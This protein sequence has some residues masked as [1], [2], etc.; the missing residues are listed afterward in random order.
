MT[1]MSRTVSVCVQEGEGRGGGGGHCALVSTPRA[2]DPH[3]H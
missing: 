1:P 3:P 2:P